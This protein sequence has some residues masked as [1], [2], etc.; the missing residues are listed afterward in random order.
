MNGVNCT[1]PVVGISKKRQSE[2]LKSLAARSSIDKGLQ[3][4]SPKSHASD[5]DEKDNT[6]DSDVEIH[7]GIQIKASQYDSNPESE[8]SISPHDQTALKLKKSNSESNEFQFDTDKELRN[9]FFRLSLLAVTL[10]FL[11]WFIIMSLMF[12]LNIKCPSLIYCVILQ[13]EILSKSCVISTDEGEGMVRVMRSRTILLVILTLWVVL[14]SVVYALSWQWFWRSK[15]NPLWSQHQH[16]ITKLVTSL[17][18]LSSFTGTFKTWTVLIFCLLITYSI[19]YLVEPYMYFRGGRYLYCLM[20]LILGMILV[21][22]IGVVT[23]YQYKHY[24]T[25]ETDSELIEADSRNCRFHRQCVLVIINTTYALYVPTIRVYPTLSSDLSS[26]S[27]QIY[28]EALNQSATEATF[29]LWSAVISSQIIGFG[30]EMFNSYVFGH[31]LSSNKRTNCCSKLLFYI[32]AFFTMFTAKELYFL[33]ENWFLAAILFYYGVAFSWLNP[34]IFLIASA[35]ILFL[36]IVYKLRFMLLNPQ[37]LRHFVPDIIMLETI[38]FILLCAFPTEFFFLLPLYN[39]CKWISFGGIMIGALL[40]I[41]VIVVYYSFF[42]I[43][44][45]VT[46]QLEKNKIAAMASAASQKMDA[47]V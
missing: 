21:K 34:S 29:F 30:I 3:D 47:Y 9:T 4:E 7:P 44:K 24:H 28:L 5:P 23:A 35:A 42:R 22:I 6:N 33:H 27:L 37:M 8:Y 13:P 45:L 18:S 40:T 41:C 11:S 43:K 1:T 38:M 32:V 26:E 14:I 20:V 15:R 2:I 39:N 19:E 46:T 36:C 31:C 17:L 16:D 12:A 25:D 10:T